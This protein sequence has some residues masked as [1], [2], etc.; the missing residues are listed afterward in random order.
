MNHWITN[1]SPCSI[2]GETCRKLIG[3][4]GKYAVFACPICHQQ[5]LIKRKRAEKM[6]SESFD[7]ELDK[8][9]P[10]W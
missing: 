10:L 3:Y 8:R 4:D 5:F 6:L 1:T 7:E 2:C 9:F